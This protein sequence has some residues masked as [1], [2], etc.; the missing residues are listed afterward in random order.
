MDYKDFQTIKVV[1]DASQGPAGTRVTVDTADAEIKGVETEFVINPVD[2]FDASIRYT[3]LDPKFVRFIRTSAFLADG[4][5]VFTNGA[6]NRL[7]RTP[8]HA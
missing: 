7:S 1:P 5:P 8:E 3:W 4:S 2:W 6:G